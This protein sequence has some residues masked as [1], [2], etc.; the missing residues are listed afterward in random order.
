MY[1]SFCS[2]LVFFYCAPGSVGGN[3]SVCRSRAAAAPPNVAGN[4]QEQTDRRSKGKGKSKIHPRTGHEG[5][6]WEHMYSCT[7]PSTSALD[8]VCGQRHALASFLPGKTRY[9]LYCSLGG[10]QGRSGRVR[11]ISP[12]TGIRA[13][14]TIDGGR[15]LSITF[16]SI[17]EYFRCTF[18]VGCWWPIHCRNSTASNCRRARL[19]L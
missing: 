16:L 11:K 2:L 9:T 3:R 5:P 1:Q 10:P 6:G 14:L 19:C 15:S 7:L 13:L 12:P 8:G 4:K 18:V 17:A